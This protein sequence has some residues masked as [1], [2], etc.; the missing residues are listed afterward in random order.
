M[1]PGLG[2]CIL[3]YRCMK[4]TFGN[5]E[6]PNTVELNRISTMSYSQDTAG[7]YL[8]QDGPSDS[9][10]IPQYSCMRLLAFREDAQ[11]DKRATHIVPRYLH[12]SIVV[13]R[14]TTSCFCPRPR[15]C[16]LH[17]ALLST[18]C[19]ICPG[20]LCGHVPFHHL[21][22]FPSA[23]LVFIKKYELVENGTFQERKA[24]RL[25]VTLPASEADLSGRNVENLYP[26]C[27]N[28]Q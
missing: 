7:P 20:R 5:T 9:E 6:E 24:C 28:S 15:P 16:M 19:L 12:R 4:S 27:V 26:V 11:Y 23:R 10:A 17:V 14:F 3:W 21:M 22:A 1:N 13:Y 18:T 2:P 8:Y 25:L